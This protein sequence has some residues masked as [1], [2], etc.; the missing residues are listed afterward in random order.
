MAGLQAELEELTPATVRATEL[1]LKLVSAQAKLKQL[2]A[3]D[4]RLPKTDWSGVLRHI[5]QSMPLDVWLDRLSVQDGQAA[6]LSGASY[7]DNGVYEFVG[8]LKQAPGVADIAL[9]STGVGQ[10]PTGP[11]TN[12]ELKVSLSDFAA[13]AENGGQHD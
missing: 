8:Y 1:R 3:L 2:A 6:A 12:F 5:S 7:S 9:E 11:T 10:S 4:M 13:H